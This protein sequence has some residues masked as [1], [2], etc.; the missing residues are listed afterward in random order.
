MQ[1]SISRQTSA[2][3]LNSIVNHPEVHPYVSGGFQGA[4]DL[5]PLIEGG[6]VVALA[7]EHGG[8]VYARIGFGLYEAHSQFTPEGRGEWA[9]AATR[10]SL[11]W[12]F[13]RTDAIE[14]LTR[15]PTIASKALAKSIGGQHE[16]TIQ[17]GWVLDGKIVPADIF[18]LT[19]QGW[20][21]TAPDLPARGRWFHERLDAEFDRLG[22]V[23]PQH[24]DD[25]LHDRYVGAAVDMCFGG[26]P[27]K[28]MVFY[29]RTAALAGWH[30][31][32]VINRDP[33]AVD[34]GAAILVM[35]GDDFYVVPPQETT[36]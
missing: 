24:E 29:N 26:Q 1:V 21:K 31:I 20:M 2:T 19:V 33:L 11:K 17:Q 28:A 13:T 10:A 35:R 22:I 14:I 34:I 15:C 30:Q 32:A 25:D 18:S 27:E 12:M 3:H 23:E 7:G 4:L 16:F 6:N 36:Q 9:L 5:S 8:Q